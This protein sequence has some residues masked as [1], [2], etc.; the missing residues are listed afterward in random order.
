MLLLA[1][2]AGGI[3]ATLVL[4]DPGYVLLVY[5]DL[6]F[7]SSLWF[8]LFALLLVLL[9][10][11]LLTALVARLLRTRSGLRSWTDAR[12]TRAAH[13][14]TLR[15]ILLLAE[16]EW[17]AAREA[18]L[19]AVARAELPLVNYL[20]AARAAAAVNDWE[21]CDA[22]LTHAIESTPGATIGVRLEGAGMHADH[23]RHTDARAVLEAL[24][25]EVPRQALVLRRLV[26][27]YRALGDWSAVIGL[28]ET[29]RKAKTLAAEEV[30]GILTEAALRA[31][32]DAAPETLATVWESVPKGLRERATLVAAYAQAADRLGVDDGG[33][34]VV[35][36][37]LSRD[38]DPALVEV[39][40]TL[41]GADPD[42]QARAG[43]DWLATHGDDAALWLTLGRIALKRRDWPRARE[44][45]ESSLDRA[46][47]AS[48]YGE[49]GRLCLALGERD[50]ADAHLRRAFELGPVALPTL[51]LPGS[52]ED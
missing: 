26:A 46:P 43:E 39:Y 3:L 10:L 25:R 35:R 2:L 18:L 42:R 1:L 8:G 32:A 6:S 11:R 9:G 30:D 17:S 52:P 34:A 4:R 27:C 40:G 21:A 37:A 22:L 48:S 28:A 24:H 12:R 45:F 38:W 41:R 7:E 31:L 33:E 49:L 16:G 13:E 5:D 20:G 36:R 15:G 50:R 14:Q 44:Y 29:L 51:P 19:A 47:T 23:G